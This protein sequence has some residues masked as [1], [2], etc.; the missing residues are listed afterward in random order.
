[1]G[2]T[3]PRPAGVCG[4]KDVSNYQKFMSNYHAQI[5]SQRILFLNF[6]FSYNRASN[7]EAVARQRA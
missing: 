5:A 6:F 3:D 1:M 4:M 7:P 2:L